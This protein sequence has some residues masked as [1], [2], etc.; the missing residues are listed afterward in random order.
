MAAKQ[1][2]VKNRFTPSQ[3]IVSPAGIKPA[4]QQFKDDADINSIMRKFQKTG[5]IDHSAAHQANYSMATGPRLHEAMNLVAQANSMFEELPSSIRN[6][7]EN[8]PSAFLDFVQDPEN[9]D[10][11][12][13]LGL[14]LAPEAQAKYEA[15][16]LTAQEAQRVAN[17]AGEGANVSGANEAP[18][19]PT[20]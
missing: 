10:E 20:E 5:T 1:P 2:V 16:L 17:A 4:Q 11:A 14:D 19:E 15:Q 12:K 18:T 13:E 3:R 6:K 8:Q 9:G 7:F